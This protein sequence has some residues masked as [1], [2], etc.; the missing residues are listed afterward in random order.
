MNYLEI[1][2][3]KKV[4][5]E[6]TEH[7]VLAVK[8]ISLS[9][10]K[11]D[12]V[13]VVGSNASGKSTLLNMISGS[14][15]P[16]NGEI[17]L[18][19]ENITKIPEHNRG[20]K[21]SKVRQDP[22][23]SLVSG[24]T[25]VE[26]F[27]LALKRG[28]PK[29]IKIAVTEEI[30]KHCRESLKDLNLGIEKRIDSDVSLFSGGQRQ[31]VALVCATLNNPELLLLDE[32]TAALDPKTS[33]KILELTKEIVSKEKITTIMI[34]HNITNALQYGNRLIVMENG[35]IKFDL[36]GEKKQKLTV[37]EVIS[38]IEKPVDL[39]EEF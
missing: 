37:A 32:H 16:T 25:I 23:N 1:K 33:K 27:A 24:L 11:G 30:R 34:T 39:E 31:A 17:F 18:D 4:W 10:N 35:K 5:N 20:F 13:S 15:V 38:F 3:L 14:V 19:N 8:D 2:N 29:K 6:N 12:F 36:D 22:N 21:I 26:N 7:Q 9:I 28:L